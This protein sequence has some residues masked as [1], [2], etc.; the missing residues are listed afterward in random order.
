MS[1]SYVITKDAK[2]QGT[3]GGLGRQSL[4]LG[5]QPPRTFAV[6]IVSEKR[7]VFF[8]CVECG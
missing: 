1:R 7:D 6:A 4:S 8:L 2:P 3:R 5:V